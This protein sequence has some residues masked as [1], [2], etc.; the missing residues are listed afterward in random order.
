MIDSIKIIVSFVVAV[1]ALTACGDQEMTKKDFDRTGKPQ[2][3][4]VFEYKT[5]AELMKSYTARAGR[6]EPEH[7]GWSEWSP[8]D[9]AW[10][11]EIHVI[12]GDTKTLGHEMKHCLFGQFHG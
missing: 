2:K 1:I 12:E 9:E 3:I 6:G 5:Q 8:T 11:C 7:L 10:G 4:T